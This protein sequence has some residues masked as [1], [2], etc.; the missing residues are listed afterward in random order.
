M[1]LCSGAGLST[2]IDIVTAQ[3]RERD[4]DR[5]LSVLYAPA[6]ARPGLFALH[7]LDLELSSVVAGTTEPMIGEIRLAWWRE[8]LVGLDAGRVPAQPLLQ[9]LAAQVLPRGITGAELAGLE[10]RWAGLIGSDAVPAA[11]IGGGGLVFALAARIGG[12]DPVLARRLGALWAGAEDAPLPGIAVPL[13]PLLGLLRLAQ[14]DAARRRTGAAREVR[15][16][17]A[18]QLRLLAAIAFGR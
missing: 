7:G 17:P 3:V 13:R 4:R 14:R 2:G 1:R 5:Y 8:A 18:R 10:D 11:H 9:V 6:A 16:S 15:G 12:G